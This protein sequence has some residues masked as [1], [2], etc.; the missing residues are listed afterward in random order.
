MNDAEL[1]ATIKRQ[2]HTL[3]GAALMAKAE[4]IGT[5]THAMESLFESICPQHHCSRPKMC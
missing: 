3:K 2:M 5:I 1:I 4:A